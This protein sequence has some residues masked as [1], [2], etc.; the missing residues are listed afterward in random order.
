M[1]EEGISRRRMLKRIGAGAAVA[2]TA[3]II[4]SLT[5]PAFAQYAVCD[6]IS[7]PCFN[8]CGPPGA[9]C[10]CAQTTE[11]DCDCF[12]PV[13]NEPCGSSS[14]CGTGRRCV[15]TC[16]DPPSCA[17]LCIDSKARRG[18]RGRAWSRA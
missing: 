2:W 13:C 17:D 15:V 11:S 16:C 14:D 1:S 5:T 8:E 10:L 3:P 6:C 18:S 12:I 4:T 7:D 9:G